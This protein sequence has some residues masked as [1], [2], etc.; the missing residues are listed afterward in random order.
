MEHILRRIYN[1][2]A[3]ELIG[4]PQVIHFVVVSGVQSFGEQVKEIQIELR[5]RLLRKCDQIRNV[6]ARGHGNRAF[7]VLREVTVNAFSIVFLQIDNLVI[8]DPSPVCSGNSLIYFIPIPVRGKN[9]SVLLHPYQ[10]LFV[11]LRDAVFE[12]ISHLEIERN[13]RN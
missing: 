4:L 5:I 3:D 9:L 11:G 2:V 10:V 12:A 6:D 7:A 13:T 1:V 8:H